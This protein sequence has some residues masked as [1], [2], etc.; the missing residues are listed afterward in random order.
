MSSGRD[1]L[2]S[3]DITTLWAGV[4]VVGDGTQNS[5]AFDLQKAPGTAVV[6]VIAGPCT[7]GATAF[8]LQERATTTATWTDVDSSAL[9]NLTIDTTGFLST[10][11]TVGLV[12]RVAFDTKD[13]A[14][15]V[16]VVATHSG[17]GL[18][19]IA[20]HIYLPTDTTVD[21][22]PVGAF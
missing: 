5:D 10:S 21:S 4:D 22:V 16:R 1:P 15:Y 13:R 9:R 2:R 18:D 12:Q 20:G 7:A 8:K 19:I 17:G 14:R 11:A 3:Y 6:S